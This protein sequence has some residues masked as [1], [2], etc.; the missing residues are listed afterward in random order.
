[1]VPGLFSHCENNPGTISPRWPL[2]QAGPPW[3]IAFSERDRVR[4]TPCVLRTLTT[5]PCPGER[6]LESA[7]SGPPQGEAIAGAP[8]PTWRGP[9]HPE[10]ASFGDGPVR[11]GYGLRP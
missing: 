1:M 11:G 9:S 8:S 3:T 6:L 4:V 10:G 2:T 7:A 5:A